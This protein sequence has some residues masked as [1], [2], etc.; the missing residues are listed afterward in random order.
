MITDSA[1]AAMPAGSETGDW[2]QSLANAIRTPEALLTLLQLEQHR[3]LLAAARR[4]GQNFPLLVPHSFA[5]KMRCGD[6][7]DPLLRQVLPVDAEGYSPEDFSS[8]PVGDLQ[9]MPVPGLLHK[10]HGRALLIVSGACAVHCRYCFRRE[11]PY[12]E[13]DPKRGQ[14]SE[15]LK[16]IAADASLSEIILSGGDPLIVS[17]NKLSWL[18]NRLAQIPHVSRIRIHSR[19]PIVLPERIDKGLLSILKKNLQQIIIVVHANHPKEIG[20]DVLSALREFRKTGLLVLNQSVLLKHVND[21]VDCL[22]RLSEALLNA[23]VLPYY[24]HMLDKTRGTQHFE[25]NEKCAVNI[26][27]ELQHRLPGYMVPKLVR[28]LPGQAAK[29]PVSLPL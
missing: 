15:A 26:H 9:A 14:W 13:A 16:Y 17:N 29:T 10:Y 3:P 19:L 28:E 2:Q 27:T 7:E 8:D 12:A 24:L 18:L 23:G 4:R 25:V 22:V 5:A 21:S 11:F 1:C 6:P 20:A